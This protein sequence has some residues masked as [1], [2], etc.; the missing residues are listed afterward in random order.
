MFIIL[1]RRFVR[2]DR[3]EQFL[4][5]YRIRISK[6]PAFRGETLTKI[7]DARDLPASL[8]GLIDVEPDCINYMN[9]ARWSDWESFIG[10]CQLSA[11]YFDPDIEMHPR[12]RLVLEIVD[13]VQ[14]G[15]SEQDRTTP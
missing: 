12:R 10:Q 9:I 1:I 4:K 7:S 5:D 8:R 14:P 3:E 15:E 6:D 11:E 2:P 13:E